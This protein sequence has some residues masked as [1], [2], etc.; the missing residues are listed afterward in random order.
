MSHVAC[1]VGAVL[2][3]QAAVVGRVPLLHDVL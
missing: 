1:C 3:G 2:C